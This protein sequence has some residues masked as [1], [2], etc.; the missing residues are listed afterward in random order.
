MIISPQKAID[1]GTI[2]FPDL[3]LSPEQLQPNGIDVR[4]MSVH[5]LVDQDKFK[6][7]STNTTEFGVDALT[8]DRDGWVLL[9]KFVPYDVV[10]YEYVNIPFNVAAFIF[11]RSTLNRH[12]IFIYAGLY[13]TGFRNRVSFTVYPF[14][15]FECQIGSRIAQIVFVEAKSAS[16]YHGSYNDV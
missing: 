5:E 7:S 12:G 10:C 9:R 4:L 2:I 16:M 14:I 13:D 8:P 6:L 3:V 1:D 11:G 15:D